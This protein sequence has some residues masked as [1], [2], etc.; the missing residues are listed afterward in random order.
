MQIKALKTFNSKNLGLIRTGIIV[1]VEKR[2]AQQLIKTGLAEEHKP[3]KNEP[4][5]AGGL[6]PDSN[7]SLGDAPRQKE[8][9]LG[10]DPDDGQEGS[11]D[12]PPTDETESSQDQASGSTDSS[13]EAP[14]VA[15]KKK[16]LSSRQ[17]GRPSRKRT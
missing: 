7:T 1:T 17:V 13:S 16:Q 9:D 12:E 14:P 8:P 15:G 4:D 6:Q 3:K 5:N 10:N 11:S 2:Y